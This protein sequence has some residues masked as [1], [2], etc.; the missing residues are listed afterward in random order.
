MLAVEEQR[1]VEHAQVDGYRTGIVDLLAFALF[2]L[3]LVVMI[4][5]L[6]SGRSA[7][8]ILKELDAPVA[9]LF[10]LQITFGMSLICSTLVV[11]LLM[12]VPGYMFCAARYDAIGKYCLAVVGSSK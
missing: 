10:S 6:G 11:S 2:S 4:A 1:C 3:F 8:S 9:R 7:S 5:R 12:I